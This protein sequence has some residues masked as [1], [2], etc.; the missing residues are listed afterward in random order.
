[1]S[2]IYIPPLH[3]VYRSQTSNC[4]KLLFDLVCRTCHCA[5]EQFAL[6]RVC[7]V[8]KFL[9]SP[10]LFAHICEYFI[11]SKREYAPGVI[12][13]C[14]L[15]SYAGLRKSLLPLGSIDS[16]YCCSVPG[17]RIWFERPLLAVPLKCL[18]HVGAYG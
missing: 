9:G 11:A 7:N 5:I 17:G 4:S 10:C 12:P 8:F 13:Y 16:W 15:D 2:S 1:M 14:L 3:F 6:L 18:K